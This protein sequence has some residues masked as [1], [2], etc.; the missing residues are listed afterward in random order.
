[1][2]AATDMWRDHYLITFHEPAGDT[3]LIRKNIESSTGDYFLLQRLQS[4]ALIDN[5]TPRDIKKISLRTECSQH[6]AI[7][8]MSAVWAP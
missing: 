2:G 7:D 1:M 5:Q 8:Q 6:V 4:G 3:G